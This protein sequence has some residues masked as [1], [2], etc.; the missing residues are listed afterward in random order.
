[1][2]SAILTSAEQIS[3]LRIMAE[4]R[5][6]NEEKRASKTPQ[7]RGRGS[8]SPQKKATRSKSTDQPKTPLK[9][10]TA[11]QKSKKDASSSS[12][13]EADFCIICL[14]ELPPKLTKNNSIECNEC[15]RPVHLAC[16]NIQNSYFTCIHCDSEFSE[17]E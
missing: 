11:A 3:N 10:L 15:H 13:S 16:A 5:K 8:K 9:K 4:K 6:A 7:K 17:E 2:E 14:K 12:P 1:M